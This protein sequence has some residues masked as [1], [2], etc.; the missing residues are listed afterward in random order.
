MTSEPT[1]REAAR[2]RRLPLPPGPRLPRVVQTALY[3]RV[4]YRLTPKLRGTYGDIVLLRL[5][6]EGTVVQLADAQHIQALLKGSD[7]VFHGG[8]GNAIVEPILGSGSLMLADEAEHRRARRLLMPAF[9]TAALRGYEDMV[10]RLAAREAE[11]W[12]PGVAFRAHDRMNGLTLEIIM[13]VV[14]GVA[15][16]AHLGELRHLMG[17]FVKVKPL[18]FLGWHMPALQ[19]VGRWRRKLAQQRRLDELIQAL[20]A[21]RRAAKDT[22]ERH[23]V[24]SQLLS[25]PA[26]SDALTDAELR[27][28]LVSLLLA[29][30]ETTATALAWSLHALAWDSAL[31]EKA[32]AAAVS[33]DRKYL[34]A[35]VKEALRL[36]PV[37]SEIARKVT[38]EVEIGG[39]R[40]PARAVVMPMIGQ[41]HTDAEHHEDPGAFRPERFLDGRVPRGSWLPFGGGPRYCLGAG[42]A[43]MESALVLREIL[44]RYRLSPCGDRPEEPRARHVILVPARGCKITTTR[45]G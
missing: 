24:L 39:F 41:V 10:G 33:D 14:F 30:H 38:Q 36:H 25:V 18:D 45:R 21:E 28:Q 8:E 29:G 19:K 4:P 16:G 9:R 12:R 5:F 3:R 44:T 37:I 32:A 31:Q 6:P 20:I 43:L 1:A 34:E 40:V 11:Q 27:D 35:I 15:E 23:D 42:F 26:E 7:A 2:I 22:A 13:Q 17:E